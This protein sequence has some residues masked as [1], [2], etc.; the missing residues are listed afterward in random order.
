MMKVLGVS[1]SFENSMVKIFNL[2]FKENCICLASLLEQVCLY[3]ELI[4]LIRGENFKIKMV[5]SFAIAFKVTLIS[6]LR[7]YDNIYSSNTSR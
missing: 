2:L 6:K 4:Q 1:F 3:T 5:F 7:I